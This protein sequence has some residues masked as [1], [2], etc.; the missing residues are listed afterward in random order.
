[1]FTTLAL[2]SLGM[3]YLNYK[4]SNEPTVRIPRVGWNYDKDTNI[5]TFSPF[6]GYYSSKNECEKAAYLAKRHANI[7]QMCDKEIP[8]VT[9]SFC[10]SHG[11][12]QRRNYPG[13][14]CQMKGGLFDEDTCQKDSYC[15]QISKNKR[16][17][18]PKFDQV[19]KG[20]KCTPNKL[21][22]AG[23]YCRRG[24]CQ[25]IPTFRLNIKTM[26]EGIYTVINGNMLYSEDT[27][28]VYFIGLDENER[29]IH[30][31]MHA[32]LNDVQMLGIIDQLYQKRPLLFIV[33]IHKFNGENLPFLFRKFMVDIGST[34]V[35]Y[36][37][38]P[39]FIYVGDFRLK[40]AIF[41]YA[42]SSALN[43]KTM[44][45]GVQYVNT[46]KLNPV[47]SDLSLVNIPS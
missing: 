22:D 8:C 7:G 11:V 9:G 37:R 33:V 40:R 4:N 31:S 27:P 43:E 15:D 17:C 36:I 29:V 19:S 44:G 47:L 3:A 41:D 24:T 12:C 39:H 25:R 16:I 42:D 14:N 34:S 30:N 1:M 23:L 6:L 45:T 21:C 5:C 10:N 20:D 38:R 2:A 28:A 18:R 13:D 26:K 35:R 46:V 32:E